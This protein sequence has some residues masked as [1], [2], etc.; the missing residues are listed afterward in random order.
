MELTNHTLDQNKHITQVLTGE[1][2]K[3]DRIIANEED[4][5]IP[6]WLLATAVG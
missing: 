2:L 1:T 6:A 3:T 4:A 5:W